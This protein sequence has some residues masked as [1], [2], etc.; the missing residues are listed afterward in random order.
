VT[1]LDPFEPIKHPVTDE[2][3][4]KVKEIFM[5]AGS[6]I[7][8][9]QAELEVLKLR[10]LVDVFVDEYFEKIKKPETPND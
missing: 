6:E 8:D 9:Y 4:T 5:E 1:T 2:E 10:K 7:D 3:I